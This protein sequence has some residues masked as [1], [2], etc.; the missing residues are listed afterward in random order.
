M[1]KILA[2]FIILALSVGV[3]CFT[4]YA[5]FGDGIAVV[6]S[7]VQLIKTGLYGQKVTFK[8]SDFKC[9]LCI[10]DFDKLTVTKLPSSTE[11]TLLLAGR[12][13][14]EGQS[15]KRRNIASLVFVPASTE[16]KKASFYFKIDGFADNNEFPCIL[17]FI[18]KINYAPRLP[19]DAE[20]SLTLVTQS[21]ISVFGNLIAEDPEGDEIEFILVSYPEKGILKITD[22][23]TG[24]YKYTPHS[25]YTGQDALTYVIRDEYGNYSKPVTVNLRT[26]ER[27]SS[28]IFRDMTERSEYNAAVAMS[29]LGIMSGKLVGDD[30]YFEPDSS[31]SKAEFVTMAMKAMGIRYDSTLSRSYFDDD[32]Q[33]PTSLSPYVATAQ[34]LGII[35]GTFTGQEL[36]FEPN[37]Q[38]TKYEAATVMSRILGLSDSEDAE[39][40]SLTRVPVWARSSVCAMQ[41]L[42][43]FGR[44]ENDDSFDKTITKAD[45]AEYIY[46]M[47]SV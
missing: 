17:K 20:A 41:T 23:S 14:K 44:T 45:A 26:I 18:D 46:R 40:E 29:A 37:K 16:V 9:A 43:I 32:A 22:E 36:L 11:G 3:F 28:Q 12:R 5:S 1:K 30:T 39:Y 7:E 38:I 21:D 24:A 19:D 2:L 13:V 27:M 6:A 10:A 15:I 35:D 4:G 25:G 33:I 31:V 42:G 8:D 47:I 34:R